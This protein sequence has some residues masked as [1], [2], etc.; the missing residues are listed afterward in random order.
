MP[1]P[2]HAVPSKH[3]MRGSHTDHDDGIVEVISDL[4]A[5]LGFTPAQAERLTNPTAEWVTAQY[6]R[7][8]HAVLTGLEKAIGRGP[9]GVTAWLIGANDRGESARALILTGDLERFTGLARPTL[10][11]DG[12]IHRS[13]PPAAAHRDPDPPVQPVNDEPHVFDPPSPPDSDF[14]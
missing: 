9:H 7:R 5:W 2:N 14:E 1:I 13:V 10:F 8:V 12:R 6:L 4:S 11:G 3:M